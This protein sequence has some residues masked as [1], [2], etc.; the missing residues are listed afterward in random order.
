MN[1]DEVE[2]R[3]RA[4]TVRTVAS[5]VAVASVYVAILVLVYILGGAR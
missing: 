5:I 2:R 1:A 3:G 4:E